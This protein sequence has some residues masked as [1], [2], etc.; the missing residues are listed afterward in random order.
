[1]SDLE[2]RS[3][4][5]PQSGPRE[6]ITVGKTTVVTGKAT[7]V[8]VF[9]MTLGG[10]TIELLPLRDWKAGR[11]R[12]RSFWMTAARRFTNLALQTARSNKRGPTIL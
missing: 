7:G 5:P 9:T 3:P 12:R 1:M 2:T 8:E 6:E 4:T 11:W 10:E